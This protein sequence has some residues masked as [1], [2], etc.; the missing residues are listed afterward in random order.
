MAAFKTLRDVCNN[1]E[2]DLQQSSKDFFTFNVGETPEDIVT[3]KMRDLTLFTS[4]LRLL[5]ANTLSMT[6]EITEQE[7][8]EETIVNSF[9]DTATTKVLEQHI[10]KFLT[11]SHAVKSLITASD[12][13]LQP[14]LIERKEK[15]LDSI[16]TYQQR[17]SQLRHLDALLSEKEE[18][19]AAVRAQWDEELGLMKDMSDS[20]EDTEVDETGPLHVKLRKLVDKLELMRWLLGKLVTSRTGNYDWLSDPHSRISALKIA[21]TV[22]TVDLFTGGS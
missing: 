11:Q 17:E 20:I 2:T 10:V 13:D 18:Q 1:F 14:E 16:K 7:K 5:R 6:P 8:A 3:K 22:N 19:L 12:K 9:S 21:R 4:K 15:I